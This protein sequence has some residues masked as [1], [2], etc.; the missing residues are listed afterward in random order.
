MENIR[1]ELEKTSTFLGINVMFSLG[2]GTGSGLGT[3]IVEEINNNF[4]TRII[5]Q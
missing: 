1:K 5:C 4:K 3:R 2:G